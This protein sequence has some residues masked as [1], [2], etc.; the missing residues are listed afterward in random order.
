MNHSGMEISIPKH[1]R[2]VKLLNFNDDREASVLTRHLGLAPCQ[3]DFVRKNTAKRPNDFTRNEKVVT[4]QAVEKER[5]KIVVCSVPL[6]RNPIYHLFSKTASSPLFPKNRKR[7]FVH[8][9]LLC[10]LSA[11]PRAKVMRLCNSSNFGDGADKIKEEGG[12]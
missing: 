10:F 7:Q 11:Q 5:R 2:R 8:V 12:G 4:R 1:P 9:L 6:I 3:A